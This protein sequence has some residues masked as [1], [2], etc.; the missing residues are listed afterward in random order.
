MKDFPIYMDF[1]HVSR[2]E[3]YRD[4]YCGP[5]PWRI[6][7]PIY[8]VPQTKTH[9]ESARV[10]KAKFADFPV[11]GAKNV[12]FRLVYASGFIMVSDRDFLHVSRLEEYRDFYYGPPH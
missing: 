2:L 7:K 1:L 10:Y 8:R 6:T 9:D 4:F 3:E 5:C 11:L 12:G